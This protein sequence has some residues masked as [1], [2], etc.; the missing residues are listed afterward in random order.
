MAGVRDDLSVRHYGASPGSHAH[1]HFQI[2]L[3][4]D[5]VLE[6][7]VEG[8]GL[9]VGAGHGL[10]IAPGDR[11]DFEAA[12]G[13]R[14]LVLDSA[15][16]AWA[17][18]CLLAPQ[19]ETLGLAQYLAS[20]CA[21]ERPRARQFGPSLLLEAWAPAPAKPTRTRRAIDWP[22]LQAWAQAQ[23]AVPLSVVDLATR[24]HLSAAQFTERCRQELGLSPMAWLRALRLDRA[25]QLRAQGLPVAEAAR[26]SGY[27][28]P[29]AL[30][31]ALRRCA[32]GSPAPRDD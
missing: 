22:G 30:T 19:P 31:A 28:S 2:L 24:A 4:L 6:L 27:R 26:R 1:G 20:A 16:D 10:V 15:D 25:R 9:R 18:L 21:S 14:C 11:H 29:S 23:V 8:R 3:G 12:Q 17:R 32:A 7:E 13:A 5:G